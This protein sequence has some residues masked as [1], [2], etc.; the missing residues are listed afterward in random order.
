MKRGTFWLEWF[1]RSNTTDWT[2]TLA[3]HRTL[4]QLWHFGQYGK[5]QAPE[6]WHR[7]MSQWVTR[8]QQ[9]IGHFGD[10]SFHSITCTGTDNLTRT[11]KRQNTQ[12]TQIPQ[13]KKWPIVNSTT[14]TFKKPRLRDRTI[15]A[16][17]TAHRSR[18][19]SCRIATGRATTVV[20]RS[21]WPTG[22]RATQFSADRADG[23]RDA[24]RR[25]TS[26]R[27]PDWEGTSWP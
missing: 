22:G 26:D 24:E 3:P 10:E 18:R 13:R 25:A 14:N 5:R 4:V 1:Y 11:T 20:R 15:Q 21:C 2:H 9:H 12:I 17:R 6:V 23:Y 8:S 19:C 16:T 27:A 7:V